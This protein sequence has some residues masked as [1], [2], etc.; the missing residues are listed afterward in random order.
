M[1]AFLI[2]MTLPLYWGIPP[3]PLPKTLAGFTFIARSDSLLKARNS[4]KDFFVNIQPNRFRFFPNDGGA[5]R[6]DKAITIGK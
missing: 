4:G 5:P 2:P 3:D 1:S 6:F